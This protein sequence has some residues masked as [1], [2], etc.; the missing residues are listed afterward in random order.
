LELFRAAHSKIEKRHTGSLTIE[1]RDM[2][3][4]NVLAAE[5]KL[6]PALFSAE[7]EHKVFFTFLFYMHVLSNGVFCF[8]PWAIFFSRI[9]FI[10]YFGL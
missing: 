2:E 8:H 9:F 3:L 10:F 6:H 5:N 1:S 7:A 4:K